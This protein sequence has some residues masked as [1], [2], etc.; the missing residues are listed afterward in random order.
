MNL[1]SENLEGIM[2]VLFQDDA[3]DAANTKDSKEDSKESAPN[4]ET[5]S[6]DTDSDEN[7]TVEGE[8]VEE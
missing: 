6:T 2:V 5:N 3:L 8:V 7:E 4:D 1:I